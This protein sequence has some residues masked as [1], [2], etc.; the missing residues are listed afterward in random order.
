MRRLAGE[1][2]GI[3]L[4]VGIIRDTTPS[5]AGHLTPEAAAIYYRIP[6]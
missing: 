3:L 4:V 5:H 1:S 2:I 6:S